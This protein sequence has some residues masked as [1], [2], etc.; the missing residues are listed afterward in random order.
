VRE[1]F[2][3]VAKTVETTNSVE[4]LKKEHVLGSMK[5]GF[6]RFKSQCWPSDDA[7]KAYF[8]TMPKKHWSKDI[9]RLPRD[10]QDQ[11]LP[12]FEQYHTYQLIPKQL[13]KI[14]RDIVKILDEHK[15]YKVK[16]NKD[17][18]YQIKRLKDGMVLRRSKD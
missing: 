14:E 13:E 6:C 1:K 10:L 17:Q 18:I 9:D 5:C 2:N 15:I 11:L 12:L 8:Q 3:R 7:L 4:G 16:L